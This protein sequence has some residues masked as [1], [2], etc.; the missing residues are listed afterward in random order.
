M[1]RDV[2]SPAQ[3]GGIAR[4]HLD[5]G[6]TLTS[7]LALAAGAAALHAPGDADAAIVTYDVGPFTVGFDSGQSASPGLL[8]LTRA[9]TDWASVAICTPASL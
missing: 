6:R 3:A 5:D 2:D 8:P 1:T 9:C 4:M 7:I